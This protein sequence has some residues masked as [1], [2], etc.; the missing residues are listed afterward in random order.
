MHIYR[1]QV[2]HF[3]YKTVEPIDV[4]EE[5]EPVIHGFC[6]PVNVDQDN[7]LPL[8]YQKTSKPIAVDSAISN[9]VW[10]TIIEEEEEEFEEVNFSLIN[11]IF[12]M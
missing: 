6:R 9:T 8:G 7:N 11:S 5:D 12:D 1:K 4:D 3:L 2:E 10:D